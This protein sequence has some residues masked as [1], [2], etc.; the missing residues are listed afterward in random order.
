MKPSLGR[1][2]IFH[3]STL[4]FTEGTETQEHGRTL[5]NGANEAPAIITRVWSDTYVNVRVVLD[6]N[7]TLWKTSVDLL[8]EGEEPSLNNLLNGYCTWPER[9]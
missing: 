2:V 8:P 6:G 9:V 5:C 3:G 4:E 7:D 1:I